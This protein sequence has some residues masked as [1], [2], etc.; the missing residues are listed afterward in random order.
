[1]LVVEA[2]FAE[3]AVIEVLADTALVANSNDWRSAAA[4]AN[5]SFVLN[6]ILSHF[7]VV[8]LC[9]WKGTIKILAL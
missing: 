2:L 7:N 4:I 8:F 9:L 5:N 3:L 1:M 6:H